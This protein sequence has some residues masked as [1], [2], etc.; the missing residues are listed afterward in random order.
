MGLD[1]YLYKTKR[2]NGYTGED[3]EEV[4]SVVSEFSSVEELREKAS[5]LTEIIT[6]RKDTVGA[7][8]EALN[9]QGEHFRWASIL[10]RVGY[11]RKANQ[12]HNW[13]VENCQGGVDECQM[14]EVPKQKIEELL[15]ICLDI[16]KNKDNE[17]LAK[18]ELPTQSGFFFGPTEYDEYYY[19]DIEDTIDILERVLEKTDFD[20]EIVLYRSSW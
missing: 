16:I 10:E 20:K 7:L 4:D 14:E 2:V 13:F 19:Q 9:N 8:D 15:V 6:E 17:E 18:S 1:M 12:I 5:S 3:Y 11:W